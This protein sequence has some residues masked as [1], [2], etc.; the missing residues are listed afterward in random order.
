MS[1]PSPPECGL[2]LAPPLADRFLMGVAPLDSGPILLRK[3]F[4]FHLAVDTLPSG[5]TLRS[6]RDSRFL[7]LAVS[8]VSDFVP[9]SGSPWSRSSADE[10]LP[11]SLDPP[12]LIRAAEG[13]QPSRSRRCPAHTLTRSDSC[14]GP[15]TV[16]SSRPQSPPARTCRPPPEQVSQVPDRSRDARCPQPPRRVRPLPVLVTWQ[17]GFRLRPFRKVGHSQLLGLNEAKSGSRI[18]ITADVLAFASFAPRVTPTRVESAS[19]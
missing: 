9:V 16:R 7:P 15:W 5:L 4:G 13:L 6:E 1:T 8:V 11:P 17:S 10:A 14:P 12:P 18:R 3:P 2:D 19:W